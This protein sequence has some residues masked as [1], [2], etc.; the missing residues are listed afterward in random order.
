M[1][2]NFFPPENSAIYEIMCKSMVQPD[3]TQMA[4]Q[5]DACALPTG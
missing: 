5:H 1:F 3:R 4:K 2:N